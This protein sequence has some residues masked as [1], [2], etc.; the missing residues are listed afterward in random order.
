MYLKSAVLYGMV[1]N[2]FSSAVYIVNKKRSSLGPNTVNMLV[3]LC[4]WSSINI[5]AQKRLCYL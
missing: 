4:C 3:C 1:M 5:W 2:D